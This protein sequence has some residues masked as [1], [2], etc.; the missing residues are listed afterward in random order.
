MAKSPKSMKVVA[1]LA[2]EP[3]A[4]DDMTD[5]EIAVAEAV[6]TPVDATPVEIVGHSTP[7]EVVETHEPAAVVTVVEAVE[8]TT[9][10][11]YFVT[12][13]NQTPLAEA[14][15]IARAAYAKERALLDEAHRLV[16]IAIN[17]A[18]AGRGVPM[19]VMEAAAMKAV[20]AVSHGSK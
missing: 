9:D 5:E 14:N 11:P 12:S 10:K 19:D 2:T 8:P 17:K 6:M 13:L 1:Q 7:V 4:R 18:F 15:R 20:D 3:P 16:L